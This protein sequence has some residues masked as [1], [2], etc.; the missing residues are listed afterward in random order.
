MLQTL[1]DEQSGY[2]A[3]GLDII[4]LQ[5]DKDKARSGFWNNLLGTLETALTMG[6]SGGGTAGKGGSFGG[7]GGF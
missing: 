1:F 2:G 6:A 7:G 3:S 5:G 4:G